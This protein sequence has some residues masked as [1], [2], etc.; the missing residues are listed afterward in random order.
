M[1]K[2][3]F[4]LLLFLGL[5]FTNAQQVMIP[6]YENVLFYDGYAGLVDAPTAPDVIRLRNDL[7]TKKLT[8]EIIS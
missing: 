8:P 3:Y 5:N 2:K 4:A 6:I 7:F 1:N